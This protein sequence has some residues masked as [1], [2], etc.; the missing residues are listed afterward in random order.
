MPIVGEH[1]VDLTAP[2]SAQ[3]TSEIRQGAK[4]RSGYSGS[5]PAKSGNSATTEKPPAAP[6]ARDTLL[7]FEKK[8]DAQ[9]E[10]P[11]T[12]SGSSLCW[13]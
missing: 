6:P 3:T 13:H 5:Q 9:D 12:V 4:A 8:K 10:M 11:P 7:A 2:V 1:E